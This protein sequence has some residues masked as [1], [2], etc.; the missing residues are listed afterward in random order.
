MA[1]KLA[2]NS[3]PGGT[4]TLNY[5]DD[6]ADVGRIDTRMRGGGVPQWE[7]RVDNDLHPSVSDE[8]FRFCPRGEAE[9]R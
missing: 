2:P 5:Q 1:G 6:L 3:S 4:I 8:A 7:S 9:L